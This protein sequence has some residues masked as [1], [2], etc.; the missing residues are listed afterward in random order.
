MKNKLS[1][2][3]FTFVVEHAPLVSIDL[4]IVQNNKILLG[5]R[6][7][8]PAKNYYFTP[9]GRIYKNEAWRDAIKRITSVEV[10]LALEASEFRLMGIWDHFYTESVFNEDSSTHYVNLPHFIE[11][12]Y[13]PVIEPDEQHEQLIWFDI[14]Q[15]NHNRSIHPYAQQYIQWILDR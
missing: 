4:C 9:G 15:T 13:K 1:K 14:N 2:Q 10:G 6:I 11:L 12:S 7:N 8:A 3:D 5:K